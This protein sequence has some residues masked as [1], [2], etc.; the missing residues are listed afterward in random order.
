MGRLVASLDKV[1]ASVGGISE[2]MTEG[3]VGV[4]DHSR[5]T[6]ENGAAVSVSA[7]ELLAL[8]ET[9]KEMVNHATV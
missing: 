6:S 3:I 1:T 7:R 4:T 8:A 2:E 5:H 9:L